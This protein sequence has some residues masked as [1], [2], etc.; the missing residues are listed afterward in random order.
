MQCSACKKSFDGDERSRCPY[1]GFEPRYSVVKSSTILISSGSTEGV[2]RS[3]EEVPDPLR[4]RLIATT[5]GLNSATII[6]A[7]RKGREEIARAL[8][9]LPDIARRLAG[10]TMPGKPVPPLWLARSIGMTL[11][12]ASGV[13][14]WL[15][16]R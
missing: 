9:N 5:S 13:L 3:V 2:Y 12:I 8:R 6:I 10:G 15:V 4:S 14:V 7:D 16:F 1:C 11:V